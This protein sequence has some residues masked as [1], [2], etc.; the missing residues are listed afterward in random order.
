MN[1]SNQSKSFW[2]RRIHP[3]LALWLIAPVF[4]E[5]FSGSTPLDEYVSPFTI[6][7][8]G[9]L[10]GG[11]AILVREIIIRF[12]LW[13]VLRWRGN[14]WYWNDRHKLALINGS[15]SCLLILGIISTNGQHPIIYFSNPIL[16]VLLWWVYRRVTER[17]KG[18][19]WRIQLQL[20]GGR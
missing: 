11:G 10:Y 6:M 7:I 8:F 2:K 16:L 14:G 5:M 13:L 9:M 3:A 12:I 1:D 20:W 19:T 17:V 4:G 15:L 18:E